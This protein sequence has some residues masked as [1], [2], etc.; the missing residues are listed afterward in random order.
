LVDSAISVAGHG[1][2]SRQNRLPIQLDLGLISA[3]VKDLVEHAY[4]GTVP[5]RGLALVTQ[6]D[7]AEV[8]SDENERAADHY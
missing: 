2:G 7:P 6:V 5:A 8:L 3:R 1:G 4:C